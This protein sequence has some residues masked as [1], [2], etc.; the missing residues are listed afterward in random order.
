[1]ERQIS[2]QELRAQLGEAIDAV[3]LRGDRYIIERRG[4]PVAALVPI[5]VLER[6]REQRG[7][8]ADLFEQM[9]SRGPGL[10]EVEAMNLALA[11]VRE[12]R[13]EKL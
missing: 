12:H 5:D 4:K 6:E 10:P 9:R 8:L 7:R 11:E 3:R 2:S 1:M 13:E